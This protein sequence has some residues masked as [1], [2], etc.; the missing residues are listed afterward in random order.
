ML[1][2]PQ[3][4]RSA[5]ELVD[6][7]NPLLLRQ[8]LSS[9]AARTAQLANLADFANDLGANRV[10]VSTY[11]ELLE[12][13]FLVHRLPAYSRNLTARLA[14]HSK[15]HLVD[16][17]LGA[18][19]CN[20]GDDALRRSPMIGP[21]METFVVGELRKQLGWSETLAEMFHFRDR[22]GHEV[23]V[24][25]EALDGRV[26]AF[27]VKAGTSVSQQDTNG[28]RFLADRLG[29]AF[30]HGYVLYT[31]SASLRLGDDRF[32]AVPIAALWA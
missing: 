24:V 25:L 6:L 9:C 14:R 31:G 15:V 23:D 20:L 11:V 1:E 21:L 3:N 10:T 29:S 22:D 26:V 19:L 32:S 5:P 17:G 18:A 13:V 8:V 16:S 2:E 27:E 30:V 12:R 4:A 28:L 7:R